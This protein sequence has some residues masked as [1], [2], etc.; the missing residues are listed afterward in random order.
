[1]AIFQPRSYSPSKS[2]V[3]KEIQR[4][5]DLSRKAELKGDYKTS[6]KYGEDAYQMSL[7]LSD[8]DR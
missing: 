8:L 2:Q 6:D 3:R 1:M 5:L 4:L 7:L